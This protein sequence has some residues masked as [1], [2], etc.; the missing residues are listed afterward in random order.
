M[1]GRG[2]WITLVAVVALVLLAGRAFSALIVD[3][4]WYASLGA[5]AVWSEKLMALAVLKGGGWVLGTAFA[6]VNLWA[7]R[8]RIREIQVPARVGDLD[9][10]EVVPAN[11]LFT[12]TLLVAALI[13]VLFTI[14]LDDWTIVSMAWRGEAFVE[15]EGYFQRDLGFYVYWLPFEDALYTWTLLVVVVVTAV[16]TA[17]YSITRDLQ[18]VERQL[19]ASS[20]VRRHLTTLGSLVLLLLAWS[21]R[22][23]AFELLL[24]GSGPDGLF[25]RVDHVYT[26]RVDLALAVGTLAAAL[27]VMRAGW[28]GQL[29][30][31]FVTVTVVLVGTLLLR[32]AGPKLVEQGAFAGTTALRDRDYE[33]T[34]A[35]FTRRA[36]DVEGVTYLAAPDNPAGLT[37]GA[38][39]PTSDPPGSLPSPTM[40]RQRQRIAARDVVLWDGDV[41]ARVRGPEESPFTTVVPPVWQSSPDGPQ[42]VLV[43]RTTA[44]SPVWDI[45]VVPG[46]ETAANGTPLLVRHRGLGSRALPEPLVAPGMSDY[47]VVRGEAL[48]ALQAADAGI[49]GL[50]RSDDFDAPRVPASELSTQWGRLA[51]AWTTRDL[52]LLTTSATDEPVAVVLH[53]DLIARIS[54]IVPSLATGTAI[55]PIVHEGGLLWAVDLYS[56]SAHYPLSVRLQVAGAP[57]S[58]LRLAGLALVDAQTGRVTIVPVASPDPVART[59]FARIPDLLLPA[60]DL[61]AAVRA[62]LPIAT[63]GA[64]AQLRAFA[65]VGSARTGHVSRYV[66]DSLPDSAP[67]PVGTL[68]GYP[69]VI[70]WTVPVVDEAEQLVGV[71]E[72]TGGPDRGTR[73]Q[74]MAEPL[75]RWSALATRVSSA[76]DSVATGARRDADGPAILGAMR[77]RTVAGEPLL[78]RPSYANEGGSVRLLAL[79]A[80]SHHELWTGTSPE[81]LLDP[82]GS[83]NGTD[84]GPSRPL[85]AEGRRVQSRRLYDVMRDALR[86]GDWLRFGAAFDS[87]G[88]TLDRVP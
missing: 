45:R 63:D 79:A 34:R 88:R 49:R 33:A 14:P 73:W 67:F 32:Q 6:F 84:A 74:P 82:G 81:S 56:A 15:Y 26:M 21:Y 36:Y 66:P 12:M 8:R 47:R 64:L 9:F 2:G 37:E 76:L 3:H 35:L 78:V 16:V 40:L 22:L 20:Q 86:E 5:A 31:A 25:T 53:R 72:A 68:D 10:V 28:V 54:R 48:E 43:T 77:V 44:V 55:T 24:W 51:H 30:A 7:V 11:R 85:T 27:I 50:R 80:T 57:R 52:S 69:D 62:Q 1:R 41:L 29:R 60:S 39:A 4:A 75:P 61:P 18:I 46:T 59:R 19:I 58:Y 17:L 42:A 65:R 71:I 83:G 13:G 87:L 38:E 23:D 70:S